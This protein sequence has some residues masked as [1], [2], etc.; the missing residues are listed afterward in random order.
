MKHCS[1]H[2]YL[3]YYY[4]TKNHI[5]L[6]IYPKF[7]HF[8]YI[9]AIQW[10]LSTATKKTHGKSVF[11]VFSY[12]NM[13]W[14]NVNLE[15]SLSKSS[16]LDDVT[17]GTPSHLPQGPLL[18]KQITCLFL[19]CGM[20]NTATVWALN[21]FSNYVYKHNYDL[22]LIWKAQCTQNKRKLKWLWRSCMV[23]RLITDHLS[24]TSL[25]WT[26]DTCGFDMQNELV[27]QT[28][29]GELKVSAYSRVTSWYCFFFYLPAMFIPHFPSFFSADIKR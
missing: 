29:T 27:Y 14:E 1:F 17:K 19:T 13:K 20:S 6:R 23:V 8:G 26:S 28:Y 18:Q 3:F 22:L 9:H 12:S 10:H 11:H 24:R 2:F 25:W 15:L 7:E 5:F 16:V 4:F 21:Y